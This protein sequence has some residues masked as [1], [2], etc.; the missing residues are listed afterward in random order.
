MARN[1]REQWER[2]QLM[3]QNRGGQGGFNFRGFPGGGGRGGAGVSVALMLFG[4]GTWAVSNSLFNGE[5]LCLK[6][7]LAGAV[8]LL[9]LVLS[10]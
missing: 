4:V 9:T 3:L 7:S 5:E 2:L 6:L 1:P 8:W 10:S